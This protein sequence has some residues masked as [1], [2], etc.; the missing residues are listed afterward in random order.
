MM[1]GVAGINR[2]KYSRMCGDV[3]NAIATFMPVDG[4]TRVRMVLPGDKGKQAAAVIAEA[5]GNMAMGDMGASPMGGIGSLAEAGVNGDSM[6]AHMSPEMFGSLG[7]DNPMNEATGL[8]QAFG[9][10][11]DDAGGGQGSGTGAG[12]MG[13]GGRGGGDDT[14]PEGPMG[15]GGPTSVTDVQG[16]DLASLAQAKD[17]GIS[18]EEVSRMAR[19]SNISMS[20]AVDRA[21]EARNAVDPTAAQMNMNR[22]LE[23]GFQTANPNMTAAVKGIGSIAGLVSPAPFG[24]MFGIAKSLTDPKEEGK[25]SFMDRVSKGIAGLFGSED[26]DR[27]AKSYGDNPEANTSGDGD[28]G[29][30]EVEGDPTADL[31][32]S[33]GLTDGELEVILENYGSVEAFE[34]AFMLAFGR[35]IEPS[36]YETL[37]TRRLMNQAPTPEPALA[38]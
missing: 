4:T 26:K 13:G 36:D 35:K 8:R 20:Q 29:L 34:D 33:E 24:T 6:V 3:N 10:G 23:K 7:S 32:G 21:R 31:D 30:S 11:D 38:D 18:R 19:H 15:W 16:Y 12:A 1:D 37:Q 17:L 2:D 27:G 14:G 22:S 28:D 25:V 5:V 9:A